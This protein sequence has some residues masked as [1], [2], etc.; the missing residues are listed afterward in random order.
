MGNVQENFIN[1]IATYV[2]N[3][4][5]IFGF[6]VASAI[7]AQGCLESGFGTSD[8]AVHNN[9]HGLKYKKNR[10]TC[11]SGTFTSTSS[12]YKDGKY[13]PIITE[14]YAFDDMNTGVEGYFQFIDTGS[15]NVKG[16]TDP[17]QY[18]SEL[19]AKGYATSPD[20]VAKNMR[21]IETY[22]LTRFDKK[23]NPMG[24]YVDPNRKPDSPLA[25]A[26]W[27]NHY[28]TFP[29]QT[30]KKP[31][32]FTIIPHCTAGNSSAEATARY[33]A[34]LPESQGAS[35]H[36]IID[37]KGVIVQNVPED[38]RAWTT[39][40]DIP[41][42]KCPN[43]ITGSEMDHESITIE[44]ANI[45]REPDWK[46]SA[47]AINSLVNL[48]VDICKRNGIPCLKYSA[49]LALVGTPE[50]NVA[51]HRW[52]ARK[53]CPGN[54]L[55]D[56]LV[57]VV[58][59]VNLYLGTSPAPEPV[60]CNGSY[61]INGLDYSVVFDPAYYVEKYSD[62]EAAFGNNPDALWQHFCN[63]G[64]NEF[65]QGSAN[66]NPQVYKDNNPDVANSPYGE[67]NYGYYTHFVQFGQYEN[68]IHN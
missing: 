46:M 65:R 36:Y 26:V 2:L 18:L 39:G 17:E 11:N 35:S 54:F 27:T 57:A 7:I 22:N 12:E 48:M 24:Y 10:V 32:E 23:E 8:K 21:V 53:A 19:K 61:I 67:D 31:C 28:C 68:R 43:H 41:K 40:G 4:I 30:K 6:G 55:Y 64:M 15:Y 20:Y 58:T 34:S 13:Y 33:W 59:T 37:S 29:R 38:C 44:V 3:W 16:I 60:P 5:D 9:Y 56:N 1:S 52:F 63:F 45:T 66:F 42:D 25:K 14:W 47:E 62:L 51:A 50:Q 49:N